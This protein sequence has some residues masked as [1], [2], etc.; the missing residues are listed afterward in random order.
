MIVGNIEI[1][2]VLVLLLFLIPVLWNIYNTEIFKKFTAIG[3]IKTLNKSLLIQGIIVIFLIPI[4]WAWNKAN[5]IFGDIIAGTFYTYFVIGIFMYLPS[6]GIL[7]I[8]KLIIQKRTKPKAD[9]SKSK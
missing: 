5:L 4:S 9:F 6:L 1:V 3:L 8:I 2:T 7:N